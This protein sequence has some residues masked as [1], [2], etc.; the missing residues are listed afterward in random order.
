[1]IT[2]DGLPA[3][4]WSSPHDVRAVLELPPAGVLVGTDPEL[5]R[6]VLPAVGPG[7]TRLGALGDPRLGPL[8][9]YRL[10]GTGFQLAVDTANPAPWRPLLRAAGASAVVGSVDAG[11]PPTSG[12]LHALV[13]DRPS[14]PPIRRGARCTVVHVVTALPA[15]SPFWAAVDGVVVAGYGH[16][17]ELARVLGRADAVALDGIGATEFG[18]L[19]GHRVVAVTPQLSS[20]ERELL[21]I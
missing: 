16:G 6:V 5:G 4:R 19:D 1:M 13:T 3:T 17:T 9:A 15:G 11:W 2:T 18:V 10:L 14:P 8:L 12:D 7:L 21:G 20:A